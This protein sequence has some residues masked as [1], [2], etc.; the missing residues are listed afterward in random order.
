MSMTQGFKMKLREN[1]FKATP[2]RLTV[3]GYLMDNS[4]F[5]FTAESISEPLKELCPGL[6]V[7]TLYITLDM[8]E[9]IGMIRQIYIDPQKAWYDTTMDR[10]DHFYC[11]KCSVVMDISP[12]HASTDEKTVERIYKCR[13]IKSAAVYRGYC[14]DCK[15]NNSRRKK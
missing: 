6:S 15:K 5:H 8:L 13:I 12:E 4:P 14:P 1:G 7:S 9:E 2:Q 11:E 10:H 3:A